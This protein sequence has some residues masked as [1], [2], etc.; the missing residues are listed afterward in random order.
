MATEIAPITP[1]PDAEGTGGGAPGE[2][3]PLHRVVYLR[4]KQSYSPSYLTILSIIQGV[5]TGNLASVVAAGHQHFTFV[6]WI[7]TLNAFVVLITIWNVFSVQSALWG[8]IPDVRDGAVPFV[9]GALELFLNN[10][11]AA[12]LS[13]WLIALALIGVAGAVGTWHIR[14]RS[15][16]EPENLELLD[17]LDGHIHLYAG[18]LIGGSGLLLALAWIS[19]TTG[20]DAAAGLPGVRGIFALGVALLTTTALAGAL[21]IFHVLWRQAVIYARTEQ[22]AVPE[23]DAPDRH[24]R[25]HEVYRSGCPQ[26]FA[27]SRI[28]ARVASRVA[29]GR[30]R[31]ARRGSR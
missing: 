17:R 7:L 15:S 19:S 22:A 18:Y 6:Q 28:A 16:H 27:H 29:Y 4:L 21:G 5:A 26:A 14:W 3:E 30:R 23:K 11:I 2:A 31:Y 20:L 24:V 1:R 25:L 10:A 9:V 13:T 12:S 8:W